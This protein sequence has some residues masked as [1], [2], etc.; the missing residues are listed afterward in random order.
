[1]KKKSWYPVENSKCIIEIMVEDLE[2]LF[3]ERDPNPFLNKDLDDDA[4]EYIL[5]S[6]EE[7]GNNR[8]GKLRIVC[9]ERPDD[10]SIDIATSAIKKFFLYRADISQKK[11]RKIFSTGWKSLLIGTAFLALAIVG[12]AV[13]KH[14]LA[15]TLV[16]EFLTE[17]L[18][19]IGWVSMWKPVNIFL[20][21]WWP[22]I[23][24]KKTFETLN[25]LP[26]EITSRKPQEI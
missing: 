13:V 16:G 8:I 14:Y 12:S 24:Q 4:V 23:D 25:Q 21:E 11:I 22:L 3:D 15:D 5:S 7:I 9:S 6:A 17:A 26:L 19:L 1:M 2:Q 20:Y 10:S 18:V